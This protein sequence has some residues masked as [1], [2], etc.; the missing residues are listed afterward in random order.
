MH[1]TRL[2]IIAL[3]AAL[4]IPGLIPSAQAQ[5]QP[6]LGDIQANPGRYVNQVVTIRGT[7]DRYVDRNKFWLTDGTGGIVVDPGPPW[8]QEI[9]IPVGTA[10]T[11]T[12]KI[13]W[14]GP[15][16]NRTGVDLDA[17][18]IATSTQTIGI[19]DCTFTGPPPWAG[20]PERG[21]R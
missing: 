4:L 16:N 17:C 14:M 13:D 15:R 6:T 20:R 9:N 11:V 19:R 10:V 8:F 1:R 7:L 3:A 2:L 5:P 21:R 12:G 18:S